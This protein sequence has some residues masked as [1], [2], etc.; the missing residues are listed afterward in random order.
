MTFR[1]SFENTWDSM[2]MLSIANE[3]HEN[4]AVML[5]TNSTK[6]KTASSDPRS[7]LY[8]HG[9]LTHN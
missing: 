3:T 7:K 8:P 4:I 2:K 9:I 6:L 5:E 1:V